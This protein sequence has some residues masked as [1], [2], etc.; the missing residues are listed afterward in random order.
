MS[1]GTT[2]KR[3]KRPRRKSSMSVPV[4]ELLRRPGSHRALS[5]AV[6]FADI[7]TS[8]AA[9]AGPVRLELR[10]ESNLSGIEVTGTIELQ[11]SGECR[12]CLAPIQKTTIQNVREQFSISGSK[13]D[14]YLLTDTEIDMSPMVRDCLV[15]A[16][17]IAPLCDLDC[18]GPAPDVYPMNQF[19]TH[20]RANERDPRWAALDALRNT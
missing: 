20:D 4:V 18:A 2:S 15:L 14:T 6:D 1:E 16:L 7:A 17:P 10:L 5:L 19:L 9:I 12:R 13:D 3:P 8:D 11:W